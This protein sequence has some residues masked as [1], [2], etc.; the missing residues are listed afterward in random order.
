MRVKNKDILKVNI[1]YLFMGVLLFFGGSYV[2][3]KNQLLGLAITQFIIIL[4]PNLLYSR[5]KFASIGRS[6]K[7][8]RISIKQFIYS[9]LIM[10]FAY[11]VGLFLN[12]ISLFILMKFGNP[13]TE[14]FGMPGDL[15]SYILSILVVA[16]MPGICEEIMFR[17]N[18]LKGY[19][20]LG[21]NKAI[22][23]TA[24][25]FGLFHFNFQNLFG[26]IFLGFILG[27]L[28]KKTNSIY[29]SIVGHSFNN[30]LAIS[31]G[32]LGENL[33]FLGNISGSIYMT[34][35]EIFSTLA[36]FALISIISSTVLILLI[37]KMPR[38]PRCYEGYYGMK[39][40]GIIEFIPV[41]ILLGFYILVNI[42]IFFL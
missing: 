10:L 24:I 1:F 6:L 14:L 31:I 19:K 25:L 29:S 3:M 18:I 8:T 13:I 2:Q 34:N 35:K 22:L 7:F 16:V 40:V 38:T 9:I 27:I 26:P 41:L 20:S 42:Q 36:F 32:Y 5:I 37:N 39:E 11:P 4:L 33:S 15:M 28:N 12:M 17:G 21:E 23:Y 30:A